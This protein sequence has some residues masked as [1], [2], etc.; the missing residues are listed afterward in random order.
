[1]WVANDLSTRGILVG[2]VGLFDPV[3]MSDTIPDYTFRQVQPNVGQVTIVG[4]TMDASN[5]DWLIFERLAWN[6]VGAGF[7][8]PYIRNAFG[9]DNTFI[10]LSLLNASHGAIG[11]VPGYNDQT[12]YQGY[13]AWSEVFNTD[14]SYPVDRHNSIVSDQ[15]VRSGLRSRGWQVAVIADLEYG[16]PVAN[17]TFTPVNGWGT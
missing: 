8:E 11:G 7:N 3:D 9:N 2:Y 15:I 4:P 5:L 12:G 16:F 13:V 14:Y 17:P 10:S 6:E 1:L